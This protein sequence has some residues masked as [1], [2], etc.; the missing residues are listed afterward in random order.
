MEKRDDFSTWNLENLLGSWP[1]REETKNF[2]ELWGMKFF[3]W[4]A[5]LFI[6]VQCSVWD[7][8]KLYPYFHFEFEFKINWYPERWWLWSFYLIIS[9]SCKSF[10]I[11]SGYAEFRESP[12]TRKDFEFFDSNFPHILC[13]F[14][15]STHL[16]LYP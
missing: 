8:V 7:G 9:S 2:S 4:R 11:P 14:I 6:R 5:T 3:E 1:W 15:G 13:L 10:I 16:G 12:L